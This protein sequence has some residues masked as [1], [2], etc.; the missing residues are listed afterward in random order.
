MDGPKLNPMV[1]F[2]RVTIPCQTFPASVVVNCNKKGMV[3]IATTKL[4][5]EKCYQTRPDGFFSKSSLLIMDAMAAHKEESVKKMPNSS[6]C[7]I[8]IIPGGLRSDPI[9]N[10]WILL[11]TTHL[12]I[13]C[14]WSSDRLFECTLRLLINCLKTSELIKLKYKC[15][16]KLNVLKSI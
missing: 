11:Q 2:K 7:H 12:K 5:I 10:H 8:A 4:W 14:C 6:G 13:I 15:N 9:C 1:I 16:L 3:D